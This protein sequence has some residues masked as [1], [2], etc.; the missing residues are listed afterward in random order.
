MEN[1]TNYYFIAELLLK[2]FTLVPITIS[3]ARVRKLDEV[4]ENVPK[5]T[6]ICIGV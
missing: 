4:L 3:W 6:I 1:N 5:Y 2:R